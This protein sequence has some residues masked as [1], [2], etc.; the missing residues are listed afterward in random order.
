MTHQPSYGRVE[1]GA[2]KKVMGREQFLA[3][4][5]ELIPW[6]KLLAV[7]APPYPKG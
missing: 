4:M 1:F 5:E 7:I 6:A 2:K 3:G